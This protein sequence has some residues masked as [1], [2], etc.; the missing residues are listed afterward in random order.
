[1]LIQEKKDR[2]LELVEE[3]NNSVLDKQRK[4]Q[5]LLRQVD[6]ISRSREGLHFLY[7][8]IHELDKGG[9]FE[10]TVWGNPRRLVPTLVKGTLLAGA[11]SS[12]LEILSELRMLSI[13]R[14]EYPGASI[15][16]E[17]ATKFLKEAVI[18]S[19]DLALGDYEDIRNSNL[20]T[21]EFNRIRLTFEMIL[22]QIPISS[23]KKRLAIEI[24]AMAGQ[25][26]ILTA[27]V[28]QM[29]GLIREKT[30]IHRATRQDRVLSL[31][32][33][34]LFAPT[35]L[36]A[37]SGSMES[38]QRSIKH[39]NL[40]VIRRECKAF[41][42]KLE[43]TGLV[44]SHL[45]VLLHHL[46]ESKADLIPLALSLN[47]HGQAEYERHRSLVNY[48]IREY[49]REGNKQTVYCLKRMLERTLLSR[50]S[51]RNGVNKLMGISIHPEVRKRLE[52]TAREEFPLSA[53]QLLMGGVI[54]VLGQPLGI[55]QGNNP[56]CQSARGM[57]MWSKHAPAKLLNMIIDASVSNELKM[58][59]EGELV[60]SDA[61]PNSFKDFDFDLDPVS[62][63]LVPL[64][65][66]IYGKMMHRAQLKHIGRDPHHS[67]NPAFYGHWI[68]TGFISC[69]NPMTNAIEQFDQFVRTFYG[70][71]HPEFNGGHHLVYPVPVGI[72]ITD[73]KAEMLGFHAI[74]LLRVQKDP[75][76]NWRAYFYN[77]NNEGRQD[78]GQGIL[79]T[80]FD[81]GEQPGESS[82][83]FHEFASRVYAFHFNTNGIEERRL[84][85]PVNKVQK[86]QSLAIESWGKKYIWR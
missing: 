26:P 73:S 48:L 38:Y 52:R 74:S 40:R 83:P 66:Q 10:G 17:E 49:I 64:L 71:F 7:R 76:G 29:L 11:P 68:Q 4:V 25:R 18:S 9:V 80:V 41:G 46:V 21:E 2:I 77:P 53:R 79:P 15:S 60:K 8:H 13:A 27:K 56:T 63:I 57:S 86:V 28:E 45:V 31:Y 34:A 43:V 70:S 22:K 37:E 35:P 42:K 82:L 30:K 54:S 55:G 59:Y 3:L 33:N 62:V 6:V 58:R 32:V 39:T 85:I 69:Y 50:S 72:F 75:N 78:W 1:M 44:P 61:F 14:E 67:V 24:Q 12:V 47:G 84:D 19:F 5:L 23:F 81:Q 16:K 51:V 36:S 65:D 20:T